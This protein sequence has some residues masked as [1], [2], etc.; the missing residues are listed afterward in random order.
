MLET[1]RD[2]DHILAIVIRAGYGEPGLHFLT[3]DD[4]PFQAGIHNHGK[5]FVVAP[6]AHTPHTD[7]KEL[8]V[9]EI[10]VILRGSAEVS[11]FDRKDQLKKKVKLGQGDIILLNSG[12]G[13]TFLGD[14]KVFEVKQ[15]PYRGRDKEKRMIL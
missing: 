6:H 8:P 13:A 3:P 9:Q 2:G 14:A 4:F 1:I 15:G 7:V 11:V 5:D 12:H 10:F